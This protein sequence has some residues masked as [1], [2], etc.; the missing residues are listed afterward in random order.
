[1]VHW[2]DKKTSNKDSKSLPWYWHKAKATDIEQTAYILLAMLTWE[3]KNGIAKVRPIVKWLS[4]QRNSLGGWASTQ[5]NNFRVIA[6]N[7]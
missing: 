1:M 4:K 2:E 7:F 5:V 3:G 6:V